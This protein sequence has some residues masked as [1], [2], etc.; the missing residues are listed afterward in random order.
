MGRETKF[1]LALLG[2]LAGVFVG[3]VSLKLFV[4][5]PPDGV[6][7]DV[8]TDMAAA[9]RQDLV[10]PPALDPP[11][12]RIDPPRDDTYAGRGSRFGNAGPVERGPRDP[13]VVPASLETA[14]PELP[15]DGRDLPPP[16]GVSEFPQ[17]ARPAAP[18]PAPSATAQTAG[19]A[20]LG[21]PP[22][23]LG[24]PP[25]Q[26]V[27]EPPPA[28]EK[29]VSPPAASLSGPVPGEAYVTRA[30]DTWWSIAERAYGDGRFY[31][32]LFAWNRAVSPRVTLAAGT[33][34]EVPP[35]ARLAAAWPA[36]APRD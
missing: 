18:E 6:G 35:V 8:H 23:A 5:R 28:I 22:P 29:R 1:L 14:L 34:L 33:R 24:S 12:P 2:L 20:P 17:V 15:G 9:E 31:R 25:G 11:P 3:V 19:V 30:G 27:L 16:P 32:G 36:L 26:P 21:D 10:E 13:F 7:P 4:P